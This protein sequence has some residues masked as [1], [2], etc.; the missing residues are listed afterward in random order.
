[1]ALEAVTFDHH[2]G[3]ASPRRRQ[4]IDWPAIERDY[5]SGSYSLRA[6]ALK[7]GCSHSAIANFAGRHGWSRNPTL[8]P[9]MA[10]KGSQHSGEPRCVAGNMD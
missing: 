2:A 1:M 9:T 10:G 7:H 8:L 5:R 3:M 4:N 6:L